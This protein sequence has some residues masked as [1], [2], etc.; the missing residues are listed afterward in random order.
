MRSWYRSHRLLVD[1]VSLFNRSRVPCGSGIANCS[2]PSLG[3]RPFC[4]SSEYVLE[5][6]LY[7]AFGCSFEVPASGASNGVVKVGLVTFCTIEVFSQDV[8]G[9]DFVCSAS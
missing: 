5:I 8:K 1:G 3:H 9:L 4:T 7:C 6:R 2:R